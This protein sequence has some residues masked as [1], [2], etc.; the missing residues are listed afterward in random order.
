MQK[1]HAIKG[2]DPVADVFDNAAT[3]ASDVVNM[4]NWYNCLFTIH[5]GVGVTGTQTLTVE[6]CD[7]AVP[8]NAVAIPFH[9]RQTLSGD[10]PGAVTAAA[11][12]GFTTIAGSSKIVEIEIEASAL[13]A[14]GYGF[15]RL[16]Q[17]AEPVNSPVLGGV[18]VQL[19]NP[20]YAKEPHDTAIL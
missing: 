20:R 7:D 2:I 8:T 16:K 3:P 6:A 15:V 4:K 9:Y 17:S 14:L 5:I 11:A 12:A 19:F 1:L 13:A 10:T 18:L